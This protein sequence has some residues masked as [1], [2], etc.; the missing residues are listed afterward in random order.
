MMLWS[1]EE[2][3]LLES[4]FS[5]VHWEDLRIISSN[6]ANSNF[7]FENDTTSLQARVLYVRDSDLSN[8]NFE[9]AYLY[10]SFFNWDHVE[11]MNLSN[12]NFKWALLIQSY[13]AANLEWAN[14]EKVNL[15]YWRLNQSNFSWVNFSNSSLYKYVL[16]KANFENTDL[17]NVMPPFFIDRTIWI[18]NAK[19][20]HPTTKKWIEDLI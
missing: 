11:N 18:K 20:L 15:T 1:I 17:L 5:W 3:N 12:T 6:I 4:N 2:S 16:T 14:F 9:W 7:S 19:N 10:R 13:I 8:S